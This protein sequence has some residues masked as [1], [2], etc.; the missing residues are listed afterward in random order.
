MS[1]LPQSNFSPLPMQLMMFAI[2]SDKR[3]L[4]NRIQSIEIKLQSH[5][6]LL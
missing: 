3:L 2:G 4:A 6:L 5:F 1:A